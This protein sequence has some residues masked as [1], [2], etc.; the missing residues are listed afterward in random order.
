[1]CCSCLNCNLRHIPF[2]IQLNSHVWL[3]YRIICS[4]LKCVLMV[5]YVFKHMGNFNSRSSSF[6]PLQPC[7]AL[8]VRLRHEKRIMWLKLSE[9]RRTCNTVR[10]PV[11]FVSIAIDV[12]YRRC[13]LEKFLETLDKIQKQKLHSFHVQLYINV[14]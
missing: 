6:G 2:Q 7:D 8:F 12:L 13:T 4:F 14:Y 5:V 9:K 11:A 1:M 3:W 10:Q